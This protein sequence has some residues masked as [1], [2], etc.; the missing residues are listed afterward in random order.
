MVFCL[1]A[2]KVILNE[3]KKQEPDS[4]FLYVGTT[5]RMEKDIVPQLGIPYF[6]IEIY[7]LQR[8]LTIKNLLFPVKLICLD[9]IFFLITFSL[10]KPS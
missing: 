10:L 4:E 7:G 6:G 8:K 9:S 1:R 5:N 3:I 2:I